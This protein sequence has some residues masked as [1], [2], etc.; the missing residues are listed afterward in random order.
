MLLMQDYMR[1]VDRA[2]A[3]FCKLLLQLEKARFYFVFDGKGKL[4]LGAHELGFYTIFSQGH[5]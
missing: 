5:A 1:D 2:G 4:A 3:T